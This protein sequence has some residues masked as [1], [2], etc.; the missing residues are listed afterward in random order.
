[1]S[2]Y[3]AVAVTAAT[4]AA[5][6]K[7][8]WHR[9]GLIT[10]DRVERRPIAPRTLHRLTIGLFPGQ[11]QVIAAG[12]RGLAEVHVRYEQRDGGSVRRVVLWSQTIRTARA[13]IIADGIGGSPLASFEA[14]GI[15]RMEYMA[16]SAL[17]MLATAYT[18]DSA[19]GGGVTAIGRRAGRGIVAVDPRVIPLGSRLYIPGYGLAVAG[20][21]GGDIV[22]RRI[23]LGFDTLRDAMMFGRRAVIVYRL[24]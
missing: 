22:G 5:V 18:A 14:R 3:P 13:R 19:G 24:K 23:D 4:P 15:A 16:R 20:D 9:D 1:M 10:W 12:S 8:T 7:V 6:T 2:L 11:S 21:T 17:E